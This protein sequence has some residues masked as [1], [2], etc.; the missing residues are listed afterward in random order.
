MADISD[1]SSEYLSGRNEREGSTVLQD[2]IARMDPVKIVLKTVEPTDNAALPLSSNSIQDICQETHSSIKVK[3]S[4][5]WQGLKFGGPAALVAVGYIDPGNW[6]TDLA[7]GSHAGYALLSVVLIS[8]IIAM[9]LQVMSARLGIATGKDLAAISRET[10]PRIAWPAWIITELT[11]IATDLAAVLGSA[12]ALKLLFSIPIV[13]GVVLTALDVFL[14]LL[15]DKWG[16]RILERIVLSLLFIIATGFLY[17]L[18]LA[19]PIIADV[20]RGFIPTAD[21]VLD[22]ELLYLAIAVVG[23]TVMPHNLYLHSSLAI[24]RWQGT[25]KIK[26]AS[27]A[28]YDT[29][30]SLCGAMLLNSA[31]VILAASLFHYTGRMN[32]AEIT[33]AHHLLTPLLGTSAAAVVFAIMLLASGQGA[34]ITG[35]LAG[36]IVM[37]G[38]V[39]LQMKPWQRRLITRAVALIPVLAVIIYFGEAGITNLLLSS[40]VFL[41]LQLPFAMISLL[42][43]ASD[44]ERMG[45]LVNNTWMKC[46]GW[47]SAILIIF[48]NLALILAILF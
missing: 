13:I 6:A 25:D 24:Q 27:H 35:T 12:I 8:S 28:K 23:A 17:E 37:N 19:Q 2:S 33:E 3:L 34:T 22:P 42:F 47:I 30:I 9:L 46:C 18:L 7:G 5:W 16:S 48:A 32:V 29:I 39:R 14:I 31:L 41:S 21:L 38:Y 20:M 44:S 36:Q 26:A 43:L 15:L 4:S 45:S 1:L 40:Q 11:I 10:W